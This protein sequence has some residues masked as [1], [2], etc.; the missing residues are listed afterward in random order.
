MRAVRHPITD[1]PSAAQLRAELKRERYR[2][3]YGE[4]LRSTVFI[5]V[6]VAAVAVFGGHADA[7]G[8]ANLRQQHESHADGRRD[9]AQRQD[10]R[11]PSWRR[12][13]ILL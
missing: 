7:A 13:G 4:T 5:L 8:A 9:R 10:R 11:T 1:P 3:S 2:R 12:G 6:V